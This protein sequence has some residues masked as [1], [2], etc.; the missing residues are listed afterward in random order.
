M[1]DI[2]TV[3][4][5]KT[6][7]ELLEAEHAAKGRQLKE[8]VLRTYSGLKPVNLLKSTLDNITSS[9]HLVESI[10]GAGLGIASGFLSRR[11]IVGTSGSIVRKL[12]GSV[13]QAGVTKVI[14][15]NPHAIKSYGLILLKSIFHKRRK[16]SERL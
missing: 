15:R 8:L 3:A 12:L 13:M 5:L 10:L 9:P 2:N 1:Q 7:I 14:A 11:L 4:G 6:A 16:N